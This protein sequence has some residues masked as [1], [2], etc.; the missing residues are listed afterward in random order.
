[1]LHPL[2]EPVLYGIWMDE[3][4]YLLEWM[5]YLYVQFGNLISGNAKIFR[6]PRIFA[7]CN[8]DREEFDKIIHSLLSVPSSLPSSL[9]PYLPPSIHLTP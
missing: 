5:P 2:F 7:N 9:T 4:M 3:Y 8:F 6:F 1:M